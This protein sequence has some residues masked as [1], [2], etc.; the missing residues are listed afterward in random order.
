LTPLL[1]ALKEII[2]LTCLHLE[3]GNLPQRLAK[4][5]AAIIKSNTYLERFVLGKN[6]LQS[7]VIVI[8]KALKEISTLQVLKLNDNFMPKDVSDDLAEVVKSNKCLEELD[9]N[10]ND[11]QSPGRVI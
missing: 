10:E 3:N 9:L 7:S 11:L 2:S 8:L 4:D 6:N 5:L 1:I